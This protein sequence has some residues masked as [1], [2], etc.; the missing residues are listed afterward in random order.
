MRG[1][2][3]GAFAAVVGTI[4]TFMEGEVAACAGV[5]LVGGLDWGT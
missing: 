3:V 1:A 2:D 4:A 5:A